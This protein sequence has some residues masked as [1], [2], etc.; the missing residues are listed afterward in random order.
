MTL[1]PPFLRKGA[2]EF[3]AS[4]TRSRAFETAFGAHDYL[5]A[6][7]DFDWPFAPARDGDGAIDLRRIADAPASSSYTAHLM[8]PGRRAFFVAFSPEYK[9]AFGFIWRAADFPWLG[10]WEEN[11]S[12]TDAPWNGRT[13][14]RGMEF[15]ASPFP[16]SRRSMVDRGRMFDTPT[17]R[18]LP[19]R[20]V[21]SVDYCAIVRAAD[22]I[23]EWL[24][25]PS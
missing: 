1:G 14:A 2:T 10:I 20:G 24:D 8:D 11:A 7:A 16:E 12:R 22:A 18:W 5:R 3:R 25:M 9:V 4:A 15:G 21:V 23:P 6:G 13:L 19:A 17:F